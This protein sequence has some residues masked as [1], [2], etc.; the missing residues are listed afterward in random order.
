MARWNIVDGR[1]GRLKQVATGLAQIGIGVAV[2]TETKFLD[3]RYP[4]TAAGYTIM[5]SKAMSCSQGGV[6][7]AW[8]EGNLKFEVKLVLFH[9][10]NTMTFQLTMGDDQIYVVGTYIPPNCMRGVEDIRRAAEACPAGCKLLVM[11]DL[12]I[13]AGFP[14]DEREEVIVNLLDKLGLVDSSHGYRRRTP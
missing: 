1:G 4:K 7:L 13:N 10:P 3:D 5:S 2:L 9:G 11:G 12:S 6:A 14:R 8:R